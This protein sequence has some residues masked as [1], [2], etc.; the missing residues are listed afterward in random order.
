LATAGCVSRRTTVA[1]DIVTR[2]RD[3]TEMSWDGDE[4]TDPL[5]GQAADEIERLRAEVV[6]L[7]SF[8]HPIGEEARR[9]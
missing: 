2:L 7:G 3:V 8:L 5:C 6:R 4:I 9:G 1:D